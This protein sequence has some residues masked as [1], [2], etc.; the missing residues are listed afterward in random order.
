MIIKNHF[1]KGLALGLVLKQRLAASWKWPIN[2]I[3]SEINH[4]A[5]DP[6]NMFR[7][8]FNSETQRLVQN[9]ILK[10]EK[11]NMVLVKPA[12]VKHP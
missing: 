4:T 7:L 2:I 9:I 12:M 1:H 6:V 8:N 3:E 5:T 10:L 11:I